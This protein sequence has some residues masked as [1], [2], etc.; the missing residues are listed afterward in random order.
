MKKYL[1]AL[2][3]FTLM[4][5]ATNAQSNDNAAKTPPNQQNGWKMH[6]GKHGG[7]NMHKSHS[8]MMKDLN[9]TDAQKQQAKALN[10]GYRT[11]VQNLEKDQNIT[12]KDYRAQ[13]ASLEKERKAKF[14]DILTADQKNKIAA[15]RKKMSEKRQMMAQK[16]M[17]KMKTNLSLTD[18]QVAKIQ[19]QRKSMIDQSKAIR[20][21]SSLSNEQKKEQMMNLRKTSHDNMDKILTADQIKKR[22][23]LRDNHM[24][25]MKNKSG[26]K[27][28]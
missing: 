12:L 22:D 3:A 24:K 26:N 15:D 10:E 19:D 6:H 25:G 11:K 7:M 28:S 16:R 13:K 4:A 17:E 18:E 1:I 20:E 21:N 14:Q 2:S 27:A 23:E 8:M 5:V 9:L